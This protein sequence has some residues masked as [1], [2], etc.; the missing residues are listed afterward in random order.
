MKLKVM[1]LPSPFRYDEKTWKLVGG[2]ECIGKGFKPILPVLNRY[3][4]YYDRE[5]KKS[6]IECRHGCWEE[7]SPKAFLYNL[8]LKSSLLLPKKVASAIWTLKNYNLCPKEL[9]HMFLK[10]KEIRGLTNTRRD[11]V[12]W[13]N[14]ILK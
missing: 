2:E 4:W 7:H 5:T 13:R 3:G 11:A 1:P 10:D 9:S 14:K 12:I 6:W 8:E